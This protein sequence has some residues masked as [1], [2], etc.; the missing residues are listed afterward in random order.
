MPGAGARPPPRVRRHNQ[1]DLP[2]T[3]QKA[4][5]RSGTLSGGKNHA[6]V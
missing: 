4:Q 1:N 3:F 6:V 5:T 2:R